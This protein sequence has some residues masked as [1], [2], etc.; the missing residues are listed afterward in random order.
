MSEITRKD[1][2]RLARKNEIIKAAERIF[3]QKGF[4]NSTMDDI[5]KEAE[6]TKKTI[7]TYF[8]SKEELYY[9]LMLV[10]FKTLNAL[11]DE[12][13]IENVALGEIEKIKK[14]GYSFIEFSR[15]Y[16]GYFKAISDYKTKDFDFEENE[17][18]SLVKDCYFAGEYSFELLRNCIISGI[19]KGEILDKADPNIVC[20]ILWS[21][22]VGISSLMNK[23]EKYLNVYFNKGIEE[24]METG[25][26]MLLN[27]LKKT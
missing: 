7:Y 27:S 23:K 26:E 8:K 18:N 15:N 24:I 16:P 10:G 6:F 1:K 19:K 13:L 25:F 22:M 21:T 2:E 17:N 14:I 5:A 20:L 4:E 3:V 12:A 9:E 11:Y